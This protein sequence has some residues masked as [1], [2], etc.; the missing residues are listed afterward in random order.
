VNIANK[1]NDIMDQS[2]RHL[3]DNRT[4]TDQCSDQS[5]ATSLR[6]Y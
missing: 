5:T 2:D 6:E 1:A 4:C 3:T